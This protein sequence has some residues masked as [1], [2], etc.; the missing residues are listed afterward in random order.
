MGNRKVPDYKYQLIKQV[1]NLNIKKFLTQINQFV[2]YKSLLKMTS[3][4]Q[5]YSTKGICN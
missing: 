1:N 5:F 4:I 3:F 2:H